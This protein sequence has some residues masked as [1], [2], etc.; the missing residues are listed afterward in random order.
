MYVK[1]LAYPLWHYSGFDSILNQTKPLVS[2]K[3]S[4]LDKDYRVL[5]NKSIIETKTEIDKEQWIMIAF[6]FLLCIIWT[7]EI[8]N[9][10]TNVTSIYTKKLNTLSS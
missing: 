8:H 6:I 2:Y 5:G 9:I 7:Y 1:E 4:S 10:D 3:D